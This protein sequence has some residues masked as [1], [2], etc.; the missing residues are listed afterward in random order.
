MILHRRDF[1]RASLGLG[2][3]ALFAPRPAGAALID[4]VTQRI[5][6]LGEDFHKTLASS[7]RK[8]ARKSPF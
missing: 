4:W 3:A 8:R 6:R 7:A 5:D 1:T 2:A